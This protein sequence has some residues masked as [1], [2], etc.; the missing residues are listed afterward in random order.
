SLVAGP[1]LAQGKHRDEARSSAIPAA[2]GNCGARVGI[3]RSR[4]MAEDSTASAKSQTSLVDAAYNAAVAQHRAG[5][6]MEAQRICREVLARNPAHAGALHLC[7]SI[8]H[9]GG[10]PRLALEL[11]RRAIAAD[12]SVALYHAMLGD[13]HMALGDL[14]QA[15]ACYRRAL[16]QD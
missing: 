1:K 14:D 4:P 15:E 3:V 7:G 12:G 16:I 10:N 13:V 5:N 2:P 9:D 8:A 6:P 11:F